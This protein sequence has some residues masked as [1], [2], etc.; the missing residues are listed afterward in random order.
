MNSEILKDFEDSDIQYTL[1]QPLAPFTSWKVGGPG[2]IVIQATSTSVIS[3]IYSLCNQYSIP[4][5]VLGGGSNVLISDDGIRGVVII[6][7][8]KEIEILDASHSHGKDITKEESDEYNIWAE[9]KHRHGET[10]DDFYTFEDLDYEE[11]D[12]TQLVRFD[13]GVVLSYA[14]AWGLKNGLTGLQWYAGIPGTIG[15]ALYNNIHGGTHFISEV[16]HSATIMDEQGQREVTKEYFEFSDYDESI[17]RYKKDVVVLTVTLKLFKGDVDKA[18]HVAQEWARRKRIQPRNTAGCVFKNITHEDM[19][20][21][22]FASPSVGYIND[23]ILGWAGKSLGDAKISRKHAA[24]IENN[25][26][27]T[28]TDILTLIQNVK[29]EVKSKFDIN[30]QSEIDL[31]GFDDTI[32]KEITGH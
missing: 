11:N 23:K 2:D 20:R 32:Y 30:L 24:F 6:N 27:A 31:L 21:N 4:L 5:T 14:I 29:A 1:D 25:G 8:A 15:G 18:K 3:K 12:P 28:A 7:K 9:P 17:L 19:E 22:D 26:N 10:G 13:S 16:F